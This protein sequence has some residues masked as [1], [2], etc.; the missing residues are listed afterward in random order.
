VV[1]VGSAEGVGEVVDVAAGFVGEGE[2][3]GGQAGQA[4]GDLA[5]G[6]EILADD[7]EAVRLDTAIGTD[8]AQGFVE[9]SNVEVGGL[10]VGVVAADAVD[11]GVG[12]RELAQ[13]VVGF[14]LLVVLGEGGAKLAGH[15]VDGSGGGQRDPGVPGATRKAG[16]EAADRS[17]GSAGCE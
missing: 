14:D 17:S 10:G 7:A 6:G 2:A 15:A 13:V 4:G 3:L 12:Q 11:E 9:S 5:E 16:D 8:A 1:L